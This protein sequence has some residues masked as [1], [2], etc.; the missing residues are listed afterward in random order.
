MRIGIVGVGNMGSAFARRLAAA[1]HT[2]TV[3]AS[4]VRHAE[5][6]A[7]S[8][9]KTVRA[10]PRGELAS[11][12]ELLILAT[13][14]GAAVDALRN[15]GEI[16][17]K[18]V[19]DITNPMTADMSG[20]A[21][22]LTSSA[23]EE[24]QRAI[25]SAKVVK[26]FNTIFAQ[27]LVSEPGSNRPQVFYAG[28]DDA[29]RQSVRAL[30]ESSGFEPVDAGALKNARYLEPLGMLNIYLG[31]TAGRGTGQAPAWIPVS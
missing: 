8:S 3:S 5:K 19:I 24:I 18:P 21:V 14:Y 30:I 6:V 15:V 13:P 26:A 2:V 7:D 31:Y 12:A 28:D 16:E 20:L 23:A 27:I 17:G 1:G 22:G 11:T 4:D 25:P 10:V 29:A 9:G